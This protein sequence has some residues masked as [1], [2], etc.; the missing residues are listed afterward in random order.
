MEPF[1]AKATALHGHVYDRCPPPTFGGGQ[2]RVRPPSTSACRTRPGSR[3]IDCFRPGSLRANGWALPSRS[4][5]GGARRPSRPPHGRVGSC[6][7]T[8]DA[9]R[10]GLAAGR[11]SARI[12]GQLAP[13]AAARRRPGP[14]AV[15]DLLRR[16]ADRPGRRRRR[17]PRRP[18]ACR[19]TQFRRVAPGSMMP[20]GFQAL[21][22]PSGCL[23][24]CGVP[25]KDWC[26]SSVTR[27]CGPASDAR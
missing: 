19:L 20:V 27:C 14:R 17:H 12:V 22:R 5:D 2:R 4:C 21:P 15:G 23:R 11:V 25:G 8:D 16:T 9:P 26:S 7:R 10:S 13:G 3:E 6:P 18:P 1:A 24:C